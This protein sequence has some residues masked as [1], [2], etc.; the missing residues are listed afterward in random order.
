[1]TG[2]RRR[3]FARL[4]VALPAALVAGCLVFPAPTPP[5][6]LTKSEVG[7][8]A[9]CQKTLKSAQLTFIKTKL[10]ALEACVD[11]VLTVRLPFENGLTTSAD[12]DAGIAK[13]RA[14]CTKSYAKIGAASTKLVDAV[15]KACT[16]VETAVLGPYDALRFQSA[17]SAVGHAPTTLV[18]LAGTLCTLTD[19]FADAQLWDAAPRMMELLQYLGPEFTQFFDASSGLPNVPL[20]ARCLPLSG[21]PGSTATP[22]PTP[23]STPP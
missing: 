9:K 14:K 22:T 15:L 5:V 11:G 6:P 18:D 7:A 23:T 10:A 3:T 20:D 1:M 16:P 4:L 19:E 17:Y 12:F 21:I 13:M 2:A 8:L